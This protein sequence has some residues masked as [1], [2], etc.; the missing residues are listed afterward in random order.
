MLKNILKLDGAQSLHKDEQ[1]GVNGGG[2]CCNP[3]YQCCAPCP[4][5]VCYWIHSSFC[6]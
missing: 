3:T 2:R 1:Q 5:T 4:H 6:G